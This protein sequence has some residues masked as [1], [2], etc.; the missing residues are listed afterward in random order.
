MNTPIKILLFSS[1]YPSKSRPVHGIFVESRLHH[2]LESNEVEVRVVAPVPWFP[3]TNP[4]FGEWSTISKTPSYD[5]FHNIFVCYPRYLLIPKIGMSVAPL[6]MALFSLRMILKIQKEFN[7]D[8]IDAHYYYPDGVAAALISKFT[9]RPVIITARGTDINL[10]PNYLIPRM[11]IKWASEHASGSIG[12]CQ[13][14]V[15]RLL[16]IGTNPSKVYV[17]KNGVDLKLFKPLSQKSCR[18]KLGLKDCYWL[19]SVGWLI[20]RKGHDIA[21]KALVHLPEVH[22][23]IIGDGE[24]LNYLISLSFQ[25]GVSDRV[26]FVGSIPHDILAEWY[27]SADALVLCSSREGWA[28]V[29]LESMACGTPVIATAIWGTP[30]VIRNDSVGRLMKDR[31]P[32]SLAD[33]VQDLF[34]N[35]PCKSSIRNYA[36][37]FSW[38]ETTRCQVELFKRVLS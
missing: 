34:M 21:I 32:E 16:S 36:E 37:G 18:A 1:L 14:L 8:L 24:Q 28:N 4:I 19:I 31:T 20:E 10:I 9:N 5:F 11:L 29:I 3:F 6:F 35:Y 25:L 33:C 15:D 38:D 27:N 13:A 7:F 12:V 22:L 30:E 23:A 26:K 2:L 17:F